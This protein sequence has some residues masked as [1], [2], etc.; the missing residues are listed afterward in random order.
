MN[1]KIHLE[2]AESDPIVRTAEALGCSPEDIVYAALDA[3]MLRFGNLSRHCGPECRARFSDPGIMGKDILALKASRKTTL[4][5]WS[6][7]AVS[8]NRTSGIHY[9]GR[10]EQSR[11]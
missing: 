10:S 6:D 11:Y 4:P 9:G 1:I 8:A 2:D 3:F 7:G 5:L